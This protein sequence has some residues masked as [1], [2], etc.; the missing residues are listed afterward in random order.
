M[1]Q[2]PAS[3]EALKKLTSQKLALFVKMRE[4]HL[5]ITKVNQQLAEKGADASILSICW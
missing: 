3:A 5:E 1:A 2:D 4:I